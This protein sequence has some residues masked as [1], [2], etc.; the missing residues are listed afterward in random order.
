MRNLKDLTQDECIEIAKIIN[1]NVNWKFV[2]S[3]YTWDGF[4]LVDAESENLRY[5]NNIVQI[6]YSGKPYQTGH[7]IF[8]EYDERL[9]GVHIPDSIVNKVILY[10]QS[11]NVEI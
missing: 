7:N 1:P 2:V 10:L 5:N 11:I 6:D 9:C 8:R 3:E 4:D